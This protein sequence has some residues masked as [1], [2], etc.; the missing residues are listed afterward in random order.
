MERDLNI[1]CLASSA[2]W[3][4]SIAFHFVA[5]R[6]SARLEQSDFRSRSCRILAVKHMSLAKGE[7]LIRRLQQELCSEERRA[8]RSDLPGVEC[9]FDGLPSKRNSRSVSGSNG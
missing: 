1:C 7:S 5:L 9:S 8:S 6:H 3:A 2:Q 4:E